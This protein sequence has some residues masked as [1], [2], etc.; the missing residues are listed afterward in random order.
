MISPQD[1]HGPTVFS[2]FQKQKEPWG[3]HDTPS[4]T[5]HVSEAKHRANAGRTSFCNSLFSG[6]S[7]YPL[8]V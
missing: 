1:T 6:S 5:Q 7:H 8:G 2:V 3:E 4:Q